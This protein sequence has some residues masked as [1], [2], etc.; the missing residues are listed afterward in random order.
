MKINVKSSITLPKEE[1]KI[2]ED[3]KRRLNAKSKVE[4][5]RRGLKLLKE[6]NDR[7]YLKKAYARASKLVTEATIKELEEIDH[8]AAEGID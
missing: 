5:I 1:L 3:L 2:V 7:E 8:L 4:V 6:Q